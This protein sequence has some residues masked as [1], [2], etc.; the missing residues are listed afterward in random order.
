M[1]F[2]I[3]SIHDKIG[4]PRIDGRYPQRINSIVQIFEEYVCVGAPLMI[5]YITDGAGNSKDGVLTTSAVETVIKSNERI[6][7]FTRNSIYT[8]ERL[9]G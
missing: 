5:H 9:E 3:E 8:F 6:I 2:K 4:N 1:K 7:A